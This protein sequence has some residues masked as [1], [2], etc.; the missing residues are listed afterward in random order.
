MKTQHS[1]TASS[2][3]VNQMAPSFDALSVWSKETKT[4]IRTMITSMRQNTVKNHPLNL[5]EME[6]NNMIVRMKRRVRIKYVTNLK[7]L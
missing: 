1:I 4:K 7:L 5:V 6:I 2:S 3:V